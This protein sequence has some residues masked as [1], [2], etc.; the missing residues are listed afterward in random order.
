MNSNHYAPKRNTIGG[1]SSGRKRPN[2]GNAISLEVF[3][4][5]HQGRGRSKCQDSGG[6][7]TISGGSSDGSN[8]GGR[9]AEDVMSNDDESDDSSGSSYSSDGDGDYAHDVGWDRAELMDDNEISFGGGGGSR[10][11]KFQ[12]ELKHLAAGENS[13]ALTNK[14]SGHSSLMSMVVGDSSASGGT[15]NSKTNTMAASGTSCSKFKTKMFNNCDP[16]HHRNPSS[17]AVAAGASGGLIQA[18]NKGKQ[19]RQLLQQQQQRQQTLDKICLEQRRESL[20]KKLNDDLEED[21]SIVVEMRQRQQQYLASNKINN[22]ILGARSI[23]GG[24]RSY[25]SL[26]CKQSGKA[27]PEGKIC[28]QQQRAQQGSLNGEEG[29]GDDDLI[30]GHK[31]SKK[32]QRHHHHHHHHYH[33]QGRQPKP[34]HQLR[35]QLQVQ[36]SQESGTGGPPSESKSA[37]GRSS[38]SNTST[39]R[40]TTESTENTAISCSNTTS[41][42]NNHQS[43]PLVDYRKRTT[44]PTLAGQGPQQQLELNL[45]QREEISLGTSGSN[46]KPATRPTRD[47]NNGNS[48]AKAARQLRLSCDGDSS[49]PSLSLNEDNGY[50]FID[51]DDNPVIDNERQSGKGLEPAAATAADATKVDVEINGSI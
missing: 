22:K 51:N 19:D 36:R 2:N 46:D 12:V 40:D 35:A 47:Q 38:R 8:C 33:N 18:T 20:L 9:L 28:N 25:K 16:I 48:G 29:G 26:L 4:Q 24:G 27:R 41:A 3:D 1:T 37:G 7:R 39:N 13:R 21:E 49:E 50:D 11:T 30:M 32:K 45:E 43:V 10:E 34:M 23:G 31:R 5:R 15:N 44:S 6:L 14:A 42:H 17:S